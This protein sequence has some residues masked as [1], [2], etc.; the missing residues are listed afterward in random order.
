MNSEFQLSYFILKVEI[1]TRVQRLCNSSNNL[2]FTIFFREI[3]EHTSETLTSKG[4]E[5]NI[6]RLHATKEHHKVMF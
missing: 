1:F 5:Q 2:R 4:L 6:L 3:R